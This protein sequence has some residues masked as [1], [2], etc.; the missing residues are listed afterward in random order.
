MNRLNLVLDLDNTIISSVGFDELHKVKDRDLLY[1]DMDD[2]YRVFYRPFLKEF[3]CYAFENFDVS[4]WTAASR[5]Y[6]T[7][8]I[9]NII[10]KCIED[11]PRHLKRLKIFLYNEN[12]DQSQEKYDNNSPKDL[13]YLYNFK[14]FNEKNT[15]IMDDLKHVY[16]TN[17]D[18]TIRARYFDAEEKRSEDDDFLLSAIKSLSKI[19]KKFENENREKKEDDKEDDK[20]E[21]KEMESVSSEL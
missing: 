6:A 2:I 4:V 11:K 17:K 1:E 13:K 15:F 14:D 19:K 18:N 8:I 20:E 16:Y 21:D 12:C 10:M 7:F 3:L 9:E 5:D